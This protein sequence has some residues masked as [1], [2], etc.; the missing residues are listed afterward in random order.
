MTHGEVDCDMRSRDNKPHLRAGAVVTRADG[1][2]AQVVRWEPG[3]MAWRA[4]CL[5]GQ[6][7]GR[8]VLLFR[9]DVEQGEATNG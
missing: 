3:F 1:T 5:D 4:R 7:M 6:L 8:E 9:G 2:T